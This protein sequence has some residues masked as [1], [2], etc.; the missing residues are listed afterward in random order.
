MGIERKKEK[1]EMERKE[2][3]RGGKRMVERGQFKV[4]NITPVGNVSRKHLIEL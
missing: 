1:N 3:E 2:K 4:A